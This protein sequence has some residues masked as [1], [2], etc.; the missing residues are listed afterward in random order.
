MIPHVR[1]DG[2]PVS[3]LR[4][5]FECVQDSPGIVRTSA[6]EIER[7]GSVNP[8]VVNYSVV[9]EITQLTSNTPRPVLTR[10]AFVLLWL[11][12]FTIPMTQATEIPL[13]GT[14]SSAAG[15]AAMLGGAI[16]VIARKQVRPLGTVHLAMAGFILWS[17]VTLCW[18]VSP[19]LTIQ[20][21]MSYLQL[22]VLVLLVWEMCVEEK[23]VLQI[24]GAF[25]AGT[26]IPAL[27]T[28]RGFVP[29]QENMLQRAATNGYDAN[30]LAFLLALSLPAAYYLILRDRGPITFVYQLQMGFAVCAI[31]MTGSASAMIAMAVG[32]SLVCWTFHTVALRTRTNAFVTVMLVGGLSCAMAPTS[33]WQGMVEETRKGDL[34][35]TTVINKEVNNFRST[36]LGGFGA[37][38]QTRP[39]AAVSDRVGG[40]PT[41]FTL[42][43]ETGV[44]GVI[45][46]L[47]LLSVLVLAAGRMPG[48]NKSFWLTSLAVWG[49]GIL[50][51]NWDC[52][53][54][55]WLIFGLLAAHSAALDSAAVVKAKGK[56]TYFFDDRAEVWS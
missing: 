56:R 22:F 30:Q 41:S 44:V 15:L 55:A 11:F 28:L 39:V 16:A 34:T 4:T 51:L 21:I 42:V 50:S 3:T 19:D 29:G 27:S 32:L 25:V 2:I 37:G 12:V 14:I 10:I 26:I 5:S 17:A 6:R 47:G 54:P 40:R 8:G 48:I 53:Q 7:N 13:V 46:F 33:M 20:R 38:T 36:P 45:C 23:D 18:S 1:V 31:L 49:V 43:S 9:K 52:S 35:A 24:L